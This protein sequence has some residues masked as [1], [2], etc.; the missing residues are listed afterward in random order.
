VVVASGGETE[1]EGSRNIEM[2]TSLD[3]EKEI[4]CCGENLG[5]LK[6]LAEKVKIVNCDVASKSNDMDE[7]E[8]KRR[9]I[10]K[11]CTEQNLKKEKQEESKKE[12]KQKVKRGN[13]VKVPW[14]NSDKFEEG[15]ISYFVP[16]IIMP[17]K[18]IQVN[19]LFKL[20]P[21]E[22]IETEYVCSVNSLPYIL[23]VIEG[24][25]PE[26]VCL[27]TGAS[28]SL[29]DVS[30]ISQ[31]QIEPVEIPIRLTSASG[32]Q[33]EVLGKTTLNLQVGQINI[34][35][36]FLVIKNLVMKYLMGASTFEKFNFNIDF[37]NLMC[38][39]TYNDQNS[40]PLTI[41]MDGGRSI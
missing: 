15:T 26:K 20:I 23:C 36:D 16:Y 30:V 10:D 27:D 8:V 5:K 29:I 41:Y 21:T 17:L 9:K 13:D 11:L 24:K 14:S 35:C 37:G 40:G 18:E 4:I 39:F 38:H 6:D 19:A 1:N 34:P 3:G 25:G 33:I 31:M 22:S 12:K 32:E 28:V 7:V 2:E